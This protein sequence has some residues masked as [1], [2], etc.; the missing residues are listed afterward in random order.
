MLTIQFAYM[1]AELVAG[2]IGDCL[3]L[4]SDGFHMMSDLIAL[5]VGLVSI[6]VGKRHENSNI[7]FGYS[8]AET[9]GSFF[10]ASFLVSSAFF[11]LTEVITKF[12][13]GEGILVEKA[14]LVLYVSIGGIVINIV[15][16]FLF[17]EH[18]HGHGSEECHHH[19]H[20]H[21]GKHDHEHDHEH[22]H[23]HEHEH[24]H[25][26]EHE[27]GHDPAHDHDHDHEHDHEHHDSHDHDHDHNDTPDTLDTIDMA[28]S[29]GTPGVVESPAK[30]ATAEST[31]GR[32]AGKKG[33]KKSGKKGPRKDLAMMGVFIHVLGDF[34]GSVIAI[35]SILLQKFCSHL[36]GINYVDPSCSLIMVCIIINAAVPLLKS[37]IHILIQGTPGEVNLPKLQTLLLSI[38]QVIGVHDLHVWEHS[39]REFIAHC[40]L[41]VEKSANGGADINSIMRDAKMAF[42]GMSIHNV[43][44]EI[45]LV[46][47]GVSSSEMFSQKTCFTTYGC[48]NKDSW[49]CDKPVTLLK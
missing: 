34:M 30:E 18:D 2:T 45:E 22:E 36:K 7:S 37:T 32:Q 19:H 49:C 10:N 31:A 26:H 43:T 8:R 11:I 4:V 46:E 3:T 24:D 28:G 27:E 44:I 42:H 1:V 9:I 40:H 21:G 6:I 35:A 17:H 13:T 25:E 14:D 15:G 41:V 29:P 23:E 48:K 20:L 38:D 12:V 47:N 16:M 5:I 39:A 33:G